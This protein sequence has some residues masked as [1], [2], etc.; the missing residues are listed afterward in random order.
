MSVAVAEQLRG[1]R[2]TVGLLVDQNAA[3][4]VTATTMSDS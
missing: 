4:V 3:Q 1:D 2:V